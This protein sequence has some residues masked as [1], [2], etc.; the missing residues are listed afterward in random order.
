MQRLGP[1]IGIMLG[2]AEMAQLQ[3]GSRY[4]CMAR[5]AREAGAL[6]L[7]FDLPGLGDGATVQGWTEQDGEWRAVTEPLPDVIYNRA[8][9][10]DRKQSKT[11]TRLL[12]TLTARRR[13]RLI[14]GVNALSKLAVHEAL[15]FLPGT[16]DLAPETLALTSA[17]DL[18]A[19]MGRHPTIFVKGNHS[20]HGSEVVRLRGEG[21][22][23]AIRGRIGSRPVDERFD[24]PDQV[25][26]F[27][28]MLRPG[29][30]WLVQ[31]GIDLPAVQGRLFDVR[32]IAQKDGQ[33]QWQLPLVLIRLAQPGQVATN[34][35]QGGEP[36]LPD[37][38]LGQFGGQV[39]GLEDLEAT[40]S[41]AA[42][43]TTLALESRFGLLGEVGIDIG[44]DRQGTPWVFEANTKP[45]HPTVPG[46]EEGHLI[47]HP[48]EYGVYLARQI[49]SGRCSG[50]SAPISPIIE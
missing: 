49:R 33:G 17:D 26:A 37:T 12:R 6:P 23:V 3:Q 35:S 9:Y 27:L 2:P 8:T 50:L 24:N 47:R 43:R 4:R 40:A 5:Q 29:T 1:L 36:F 28:R 34:M 19:M 41:D 38:F 21:S 13:T 42:R 48:F 44:L 31:Q 45:L 39:P 32:V 15:R 20:S 10:G 18:T 14:N 22:M 30:A 16:A 7:F 46:L 25:F 11:A